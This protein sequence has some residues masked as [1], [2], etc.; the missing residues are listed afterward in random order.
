MVRDVTRACR[1]RVQSYR[2]GA[3]AATRVPTCLPDAAYPQARTAPLALAELV[4]HGVAMPK[5]PLFALAAALA[6]AGVA[7]GSTA[8]SAESPAQRLDAPAQLEI[9]ALFDRPTS[10]WGPGHRGIDLW[11]GDGESVASPGP[12]VVTFAASIAGRGVV[13]V[14][15]PAGLRSTL[16][17]V[18]ASVHVGDSV[19]AGQS[20]GALQ[21][22]GSHCAPRAC[23]HW[24]VR[25]GHEYLDPLDVLRGYGPIR[26]LPMRQ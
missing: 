6:L 21:L 25:L 4:P 17:P 13:V 12:G 5:L 7:A 10:D 9:A 16:E 19:R 14:R 3:T 11:L 1:M 24:G 20:V 26:L 15:H 2:T 23:L 8:S 18:T 22:A